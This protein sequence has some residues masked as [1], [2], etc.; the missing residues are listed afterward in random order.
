VEESD[1]TGSLVVL[2][3]V[4]VPLLPSTP[5]EGTCEKVMVVV[6]EAE[7]SKEI[8]VKLGGRV[9]I[10]W[11]SCCCCFCCVFSRFLVKFVGRVGR[12]TLDIDF[13]FVPVD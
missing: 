9:A 3:L 11:V 4:L 1:T 2:L 7:G 12:E 8:D 10:G 13:P 5:S 6:V